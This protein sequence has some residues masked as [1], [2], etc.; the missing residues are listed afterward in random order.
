MA[1]VRTRAVLFNGGMHTVIRNSKETVEQVM[2]LIADN[3]LAGEDLIVTTVRVVAA[4]Y[5]QQG[6]EVSEEHLAAGFELATDLGIDEMT[7][8]E[9][10]SIELGQLNLSNALASAVLQGFQVDEVMAL[11]KQLIS[12]NKQAA[13]TNPS[14]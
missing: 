7:V 5:E 4:L 9:D 6:K 10:G 11:K 12:V 14:N 1:N 13:P 3:R 8:E 2:A